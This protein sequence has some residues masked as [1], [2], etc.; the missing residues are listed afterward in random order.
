MVPQVNIIEYVKETDPIVGGV[1]Y[2]PTAVNVTSED[3]TSFVGTVSEQEYGNGTYS[4]NVS[5]S[6]STRPLSRLYDKIEGTTDNE[7]IFD[8]I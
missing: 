8:R 7:R 6:S 2:P 5:G 4:I 3:G 1:S